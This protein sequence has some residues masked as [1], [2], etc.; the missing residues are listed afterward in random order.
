MLEKTEESWKNFRMV[1]AMFLRHTLRR[2]C[3]E[4]DKSV[5]MFEAEK[6]IREPSIWRRSLYGSCALPLSAGIAILCLT[7]P[8]AAWL[9][10]QE[11]ERACAAL[12][13][14]SD[15]Q[16]ADDPRSNGGTR[17]ASAQG[18]VT[19]NTAESPEQLVCTAYL[20]GFL[21][22][23]ASKEEVLREAQPLATDEETF[24]EQALRTRAGTRAITAWLERAGRPD[25]CVGD[26]VTVAELVTSLETYFENRTVDAEARYEVL[27]DA[28]AT[29]FPCNPR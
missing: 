17:N 18:D 22:G 1:A 7:R 25:F 8:A 9:P 2:M 14:E 23:I 20:Q 16:G 3:T 4:R 26:D 21:A 13:G 12:H 27:H 29:A 24:A 15:A 10:S 28:L 6:T 11:I 5:R 19:V